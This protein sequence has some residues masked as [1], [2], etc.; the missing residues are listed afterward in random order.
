MMISKVSK[1]YV[2]S[3]DTLRYYERVGLIPRVTRTSG[4]IRDYTGTDCGWVEFIKCMRN[5]YAF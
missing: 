4:D 5:A 1:K 2:I 3:E